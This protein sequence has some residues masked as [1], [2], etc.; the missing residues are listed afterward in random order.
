MTVSRCFGCNFKPNIA[1]AS[2]TIFDN[3]LLVPRQSESL[4]QGTRHDV[5]RPASADRHYDSDRFDGINL[6]GGSDAD[7]GRQHTCDQYS[8]DGGEGFH[9]EASK[10][11][12]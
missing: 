11:Q 6:L 3:D 1:A 10:A 7:K 9:R 4:S 12:C 5:G 8:R 2:G